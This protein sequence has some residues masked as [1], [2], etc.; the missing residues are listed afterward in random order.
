MISE[1]CVKNGMIRNGNMSPKLCTESE[2]FASD[3]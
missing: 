1:P 2:A 3:S